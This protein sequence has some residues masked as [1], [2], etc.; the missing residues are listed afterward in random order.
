MIRRWLAILALTALP[1]VA[2]ADI[3]MLVNGLPGDATAKGHEKWIRVASLDW[4]V[5]AQTSWTA[6]GG[7][8]VGKP[9]PDKMAL[10]LP[11][12]PWSQYFMRMIGLGKALPKVVFDATASDGRPLYRVTVEGMFLTQYRIASLLETPLPQDHIDVVFKI[13]KIEYYATG[14]DGKLV[15]TTV[16]WNIPLQT[17]V[18]GI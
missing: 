14:A 8:S 9:N 5:Q 3:F 6:G 12:G 1:V 4:K 11:T 7:V 15:T 16:E 2:Q 18:P 17:V 10:V 13:V